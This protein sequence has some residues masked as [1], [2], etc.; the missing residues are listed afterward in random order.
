MSEGIGTSDVGT[1][2]ALSCPRCAEP[3]QV[4]ESLGLEAD[5]CGRCGGLWLDRGE[6]ERASRPTGRMVGGL[7]LEREVPESLDVAAPI[8][9]PRCGRSCLRERYASSN[10]EIDRCGCGVWLDQ[11]E[12][13]RITAHRKVLLEKLG[14]RAR[15]RDREAMERD[16]TRRYF[17]LM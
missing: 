1:S 8:G 3:M 6:C 17:D 10:V 9:C 7:V 4:V 5:R 15:G 13:E 12:L 2:G 14:M 16:F 11:G